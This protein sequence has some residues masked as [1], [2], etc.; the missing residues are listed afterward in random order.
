MKKVG[1]GI[2]GCGGIASY[3][4]IPELR[5]VNEARIVSVSDIKPHRAELTAKKFGVKSWYADYHHLL[6][7]DDVEAVVVATPHP[8][9]AQIAIDSMEAGKHVIIQKPMTT[10][11]KD[12]DRIVEAAKRHSSLKA[13]ALP[14]VYFDLPAFDYAKDLLNKGELG[15]SRL[16]PIRTSQA[17]GRHRRVCT[18]LFPRVASF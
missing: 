15:S 6:A 10:S 7:R 17:L 13:M 5:E 9:H 12:A 16:V 18:G 11:V 4:H 2:I 14:F 3:F 8:T 1:F